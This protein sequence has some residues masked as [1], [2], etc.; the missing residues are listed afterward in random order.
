[1]EER[2]D[3]IDNKLNELVRITGNLVTNIRDLNENARITGEQIQRVE[4]QIES[5]TEQQ[6]ITAAQLSD[7]ARVVI[8]TGKN[9]NSMNQ[10]FV[11]TDAELEKLERRLTT[12]EEK[13]AA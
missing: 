9:V 1:M 7:V 2:L 13:I 5:L 10:R 11:R 6:K 8:E 4:N 3:S 12:I